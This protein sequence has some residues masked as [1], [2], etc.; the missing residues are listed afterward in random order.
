MS[1]LRSP[2]HAT[3]LRSSIAAL[4]TRL[5]SLRARAWE[6]LGRLSPVLRSQA[7]QSMVESS[8]LLATLLGGLAVGGVALNK[9]HPDMMNALSIH[10]RGI[11]FALSLPFP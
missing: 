7:G 9:T 3:A 11:Y 10:V 6:R 8:V 1:T 5:L 2:G 4:E